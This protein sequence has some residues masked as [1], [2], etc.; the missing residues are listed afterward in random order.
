MAKTVFHISFQSR[1]NDKTACP[2][3]CSQCVKAVN[4]TTTLRADKQPA[5]SQ[6]PGDK[7]RLIF[8]LKVKRAQR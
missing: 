6:G 7:D 1:Y 5:V 8:S 2:F 3:N 4:S